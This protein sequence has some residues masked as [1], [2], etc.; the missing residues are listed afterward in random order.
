MHEDRSTF[1][2]SS[3]RISMEIDNK[4]IEVKDISL[5]GA[6]V[7]MPPEFFKTHPKGVCKI[8]VNYSEFDL[9]YVLYRCEGAEQVIHFNYGDEELKDL[10][11][12]TLKNI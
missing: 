11:L 7:E 6:K 1:R 5:T 3:D 2:V 12:K 8:A 10:F 4:H 9:E